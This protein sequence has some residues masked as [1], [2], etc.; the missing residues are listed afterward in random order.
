MVR[1][2]TLTHENWKLWVIFRWHFGLFFF[3]LKIIIFLDSAFSQASR[4]LRHSLWHCWLPVYV[5]CSLSDNCICICFSFI[6]ICILVVFVLLVASL[7]CLFPPQYETWLPQPHPRPLSLAPN[8]VYSRQAQYC[9]EEKVLQLFR[10][11]WPESP[12]P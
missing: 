8:S 2:W 5:V 10:R 6:C 12:S 11:S 9:N 3:S 7:C 1:N 4:A